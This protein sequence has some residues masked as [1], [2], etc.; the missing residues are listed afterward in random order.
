MK[1]N[2]ILLII[3]VVVGGLGLWLFRGFQHAPAGKAE[4][5]TIGTPLNESSA[6]IFIAEDRQFFA[7]NGLKAVIGEHDFGAL[8]V[9][10]MLR[11]ERDIAVAT[12]FP[13]VVKILQKEKVRT[14][15]SIGKFEF[16]YLVGRKDRGIAKISD[17]KGKKVA[18]ARWT[19]AEFHLGRCLNLNGMNIDEITLVDRQG[20]EQLADAVV[21]GDV[22]AVVTQQP[23]AASAAE[24]LG[25]NGVVW[26]VQS[27]QAMYTP[28]ICRDE[29]I[30]RNPDP[31][32]RLLKS[33][34]QAEE[35]AMNHRGEV[36]AV[37]QKRLNLKPSYTKTVWLRNQFSLSLDQALVTAMEDE[38]RW[39]IKNNLT[40]EREVPDFVKYIHEDGLKE[41]RPA[42]VGIIR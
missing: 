41:V 20:S 16:V 5:I 35:Y 23:Y 38:A 11:G 1:K 21:N 2:I 37:L 9:N 7:K 39:M 27:G 24:R 18:T 34:A 12:E 29:W 3:V 17:L 30:N 15:G 19:I 6:L 31:V 28:V 4:S 13:L 32:K 42:A 33:L 25:L 36:E 22:D 26:P 10:A 40:K 8:A 14:V